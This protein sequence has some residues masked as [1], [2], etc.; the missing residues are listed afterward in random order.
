M[1]F[2]VLAQCA[3]Y[4]FKGRCFDS[5]PFPKNIR[6][7][8]PGGRDVPAARPLPINTHLETWKHEKHCIFQQINMIP[9]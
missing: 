3:S 7:E 1:T 2:V 9:P 4:L 5:S 6:A 8:T